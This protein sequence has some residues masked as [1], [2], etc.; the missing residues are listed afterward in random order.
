MI[1]GRGHLNWDH[2][3][4]KVLGVGIDQGI[5]IVVGFKFSHHM[6]IINNDQKVYHLLIRL[7]CVI[8]LYFLRILVERLLVTLLVSTKIVRYFSR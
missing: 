5:V 4:I 3:L 7:N 2:P 8:K 6:M 1:S